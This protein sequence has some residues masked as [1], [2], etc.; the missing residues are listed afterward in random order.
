MV[1]L[2]IEKESKL[3]TAIDLQRHYE[4]NHPTKT[5]EVK[6]GKNIGKCGVPFDI[7][8]EL[9]MLMPLK[10]L[11]PDT[12]DMAKQIGIGQ[13]LF[14]LSTKAYA[15]LFV[16]LTILNLPIFTFYYFGRDKSEGISVFSDFSLGNVGSSHITCGTSRYAGIIYGY[17]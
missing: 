15:W 2:E 8:D 10:D 12:T 14:L 9:G 3:P 6:D 17:S 5:E 13:S 1:D 7:K 11:T 16:F 4:E